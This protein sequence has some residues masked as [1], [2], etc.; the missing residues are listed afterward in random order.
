VQR[1][2]SQGYY[3][4]GPLAVNAPLSVIGEYLDGSDRTT[5]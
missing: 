5:S 1:Y 4:T 2:L 3:F